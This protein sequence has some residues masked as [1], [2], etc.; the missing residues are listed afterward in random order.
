MEHTANGDPDQGCNYPVRLTGRVAASAA[1]IETSELI[2]TDEGG[3]FITRFR[4]LDP[5]RL[6]EVQGVTDLGELVTRVD[7]Y[8]VHL[9]DG[10]VELP[11]AAPHISAHNHWNANRPG[12]TLFIPIVDMAQQVLDFLA[13]FL[14]GGVFPW[15]PIRDRPCGDLDRFVATGMLDAR[16]RMSIVDIEQYVLA[17]AP[18][19]SA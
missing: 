17:L 1:G 13:I 11:A 3:T 4:D 5:A 10:R 7:E 6:Q 8:C 16:K 15:D 18:S 14:A 2:V 19:S 9:F 12:T